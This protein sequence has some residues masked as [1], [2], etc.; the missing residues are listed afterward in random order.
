MKVKQLVWE[1]YKS[2]DYR[3]IVLWGIRYKIN[4]YYDVSDIPSYRIFIDATTLISHF[5][6]QSEEEIGIYDTLDE[7]KAAC[8]AHYE[9]LILSGLEIE[10]ETK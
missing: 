1:E 10:D 2:N 6:T 4:H 8:Q 5:G 3:V 9:Y 7:A